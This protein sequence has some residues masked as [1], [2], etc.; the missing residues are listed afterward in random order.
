MSLA[1]NSAWNGLI[2]I[3]HIHYGRELLSIDSPILNYSLAIPL[4]LVAS[5]FAI[6]V[7]GILCTPYVRNWPT[8][9]KT[10]QYLFF[11]F[12]F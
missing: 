2:D 1:V 12:L 7:L 8:V 11:F 6:F 5:L 9:Y 3:P 10:D 4:L